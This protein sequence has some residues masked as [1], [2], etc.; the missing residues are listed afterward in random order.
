MWCSSLENL[1]W[2]VE[3]GANC[4]TVDEVDRFPN[5]ANLDYLIFSERKL[6]SASLWNV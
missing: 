3:H 2:F 4:K 6:A 5:L 1:K